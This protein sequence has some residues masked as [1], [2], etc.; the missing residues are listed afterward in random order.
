MADM[1]GGECP[2]TADMSGVTPD[3]IAGLIKAGL[4]S[5]LPSLHHSLHTGQVRT[6]FQQ[7]I[8]HLL[9][10]RMAINN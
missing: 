1:T 9:R 5:A 8:K 2:N 4:H 10:R 7:Q 6:L 3:L